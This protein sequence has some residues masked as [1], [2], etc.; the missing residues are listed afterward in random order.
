MT[1]TELSDQQRAD[2]LE[3]DR[4]MRGVCA[5]LARV[6]AKANPALMLQFYGD[7]VAA[8]AASLA[9]A[10]V[11]PQTTDLAGALPLTAA[12]TR[13]AHTLLWDLNVLLQSKMSLLVKL[14]GVNSPG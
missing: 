14:V 4:Y 12:E 7:R 10:E 3:Y 11:V 2:I 8:P 9:D 13:A 5:E 6:A 1:W